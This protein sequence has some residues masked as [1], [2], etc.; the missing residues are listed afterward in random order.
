MV[1]TLLYHL[2]IF[3]H[4]VFTPNNV[5]FAHSQSSQHTHCFFAT[6]SMYACNHGAANVFFYQ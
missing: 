5:L 6:Y 4:S 3:V 1:Y 2:Y